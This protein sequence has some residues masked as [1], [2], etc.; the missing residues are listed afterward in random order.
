MK[1]TVDKVSLPVLAHYGPDG[2]AVAVQVLDIVRSG[3]LGFDSSTGLSMDF[4]G[5]P[6]AAYAHRLALN[7]VAK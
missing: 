1:T 6:A 2:Q 7:S 4:G 5:A 3:W